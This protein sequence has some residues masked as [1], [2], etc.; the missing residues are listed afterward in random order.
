[1]K[2]F[3]TTPEPPKSFSE[4]GSPLEDEWHPATNET[5]AKPARVCFEAHKA[6]MIFSL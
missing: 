2:L 1:M 5:I 6:D 3:R 4:A